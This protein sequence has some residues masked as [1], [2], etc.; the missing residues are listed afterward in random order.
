MP[1]KSGK[2]PE[3]I[4]ANIRELHHGPQFARTEAAHGEDTAHRQAVAIA[5]ETARKSRAKGGKVHVGPIKGDGPGRVDIHEAKVPDGSYILSAD[6]VSHLGQSNTDSGLKRA[7][8]LFGIGGKY[9]VPKGHKDGGDVTGKEPVDCVL[10]SGEFGIHPRIV[11]NIGGG[12]IERGHKILDRFSM[13]I[14]KDHVKTLLGLPPP[15]C[16]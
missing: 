8:E 16:D 6:V 4:S 9:D 5:L 1:L 13:N 7:N 15:A 2:S 14:R 10:A 12:D 11:R 3:T